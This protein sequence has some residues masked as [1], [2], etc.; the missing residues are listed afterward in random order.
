MK[1]M[2]SAIHAAFGKYK[3]FLCEEMKFPEFQVAVQSLRDVG[4]WDTLERVVVDGC[5]S[6]EYSAISTVV[7]NRRLRYSA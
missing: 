7:D 4:A 1:R 5:D 2:A 3:F 6:L